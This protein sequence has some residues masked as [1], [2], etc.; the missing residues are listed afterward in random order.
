M[1]LIMIIFI[2]LVS[3]MYNVC[4]NVE[5]KAPEVKDWDAFNKATI[6]M[7]AKDIQKGLRQGRW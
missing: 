3:C 4:A 2:L 5:K 1:D 7:N 6:G